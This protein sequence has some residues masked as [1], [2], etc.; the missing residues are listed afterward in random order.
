M[1]FLRQFQH[2]L[3]RS[4]AWSLVAAKPLR[5]FFEALGQ[6][7]TADA[8]EFVDLAYLDLFPETTR[9]L[10]TWE[11]QFNL[12]GVG[13]EDERRVALSAR[14]KA[15]GGQSPSYLQGVMQA[16]GFDVYLHEW[17]YYS[18]T[19]TSKS[20]SVNAEENGPYSLAFNND[21]TK[22]YVA[23]TT[24]ATVYEYDLSTAWD[25]ST[26]TYSTRNLDVST[27]D[28]QPMALR[29][30]SDGTKLIMLGN[31]SQALYQYDLSTAYDVS[32]GSYASV[33]FD[34][35]SD[36]NL[37]RGL[38]FNDDG[39]KMYIVGQQNNS[40]YEYGLSTAYDVS[41]AVLS[42]TFGVAFSGAGG[43]DFNGDGTLLYMNSASSDTVEAYTLSTAY[44]LSTAAYERE[45][46]DLSSQ[47]TISTDLAV[48]NSGNS[49]YVLGSNTDTVYEYAR[50]V[51]AY[52]PRDY[53]TSA[54]VGATQ[55]GEA[56]AQCGELSA[57][58]GSQ[59]VN[60]TGYI[61]NKTLNGQAPPPIPTDPDTWPFFL[62]WGGETF[63]DYAAIS[64][65]LR[66][67]FERLLL[68]ICPTHLWLV[69][70]VAYSSGEDDTISLLV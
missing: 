42:Y 53:T 20:K 44:D 43:I 6:S 10:E 32:T 19:Y 9:E 4:E 63:G 58:C 34:P 51:T 29:F 49:V 57:Y 8:V 12:S 24:N 33:T 59:L 17:H 11:T 30:N 2:L 39:T 56:L 23:G 31:A 27:E 21:G 48:G 69:T 28:A 5:L 52:D 45:W 61:V 37:P 67:E 35:S 55:C 60:N 15:L 64:D 18:G 25:V 47:E 38:A 3:P 36:D 54:L 62:Y 50:T 14:W 41:T 16:A 68:Q 26:A 66:E 40:I 70:M 65:T 1:R 7:P 46:V 13:D 22:M